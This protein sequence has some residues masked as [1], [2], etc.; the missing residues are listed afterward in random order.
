MLLAKGAG[1][2]VRSFGSILP[3]GRFSVHPQR[4]VAFAVQRCIMYQA[5]AKGQVVGT[6]KGGE[7]QCFPPVRVRDGACGCCMHP[8]HALRSLPT[9]DGTAP[10]HILYPYA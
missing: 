8:C 1:Y 2:P 3:F 10:T 4:S 6:R 7:D 5:K 9:R